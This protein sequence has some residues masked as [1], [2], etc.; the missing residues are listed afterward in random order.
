MSFN[1]FIFSMK[2]LWF[3]GCF[4]FI[5]SNSYA[6]YSLELIMLILSNGFIKFRTFEFSIDENGRCVYGINYWWWF[7]IYWIKCVLM[8]FLETRWVPIFESLWVKTTR[9]WFSLIVLPSSNTFWNWNDGFYWKFVSFEFINDA[10]WFLEFFI[11][12][13]WEF[14][15]FFVII[16][17]LWVPLLC[18]MLLLSYFSN[19]SWKTWV[20]GRTSISCNGIV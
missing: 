10:C 13:G 7:G 14:I 2:I 15:E 4:L 18:L 11:E 1:V 20:W 3:A 17:P 19:D 8:S 9:L 5:P 16:E 6:L 12:S